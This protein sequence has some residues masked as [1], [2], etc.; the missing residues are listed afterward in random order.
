MP[1]RLHITVHGRVQGVFF[2]T[3]A[4]KR[5]IELGLTGFV[6]NDAGG[7]VSILAEGPEERLQA[8]LDW[9]YTGPRWAKVEKVDFEWMGAT[10]EYRDFSIR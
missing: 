10:G 6:Q 4:Q 3:T 5:A 8:L 7:S 2:R 9:C 1:K